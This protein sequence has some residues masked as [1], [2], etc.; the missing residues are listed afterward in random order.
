VAEA[1]SPLLLTPTLTPKSRQIRQTES[2]GGKQ[3]D[4]PC[5]SGTI[6][7]KP[8]RGRFLCRS[9]CKEYE[10]AAISPPYSL[11]LLLHPNLGRFDKRK[12]PGGKQGDRPCT[13]G[14]IP[15]KPNRGRFL[16]RSRCKEYAAEAIH[17]PTPYTYSYTQISTDSAIRKVQVETPH[18]PDAPAWLP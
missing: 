8:N 4:R 12:S 14:T 1:I 9:R 6:P 10:G 16:C 5:A 2:P 15:I 17:S 7:I 11:H 13:S 18:K 3:G